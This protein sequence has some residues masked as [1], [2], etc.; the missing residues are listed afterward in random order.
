MP[1]LTLVE[2]TTSTVVVVD[3]R[4]LVR[5]GIAASLAPATQVTVEQR[6]RNRAGDAI[7]SLGPDVLVVVLRD[8]DPTLFDLIATARGVAPSLGILVLCDSVTG[9]D[10]REAVLSGVDSLLLTKAPLGE[11]RRA[12][13]ATAAGDRVVSPEIAMHLAV[14]TRAGTPPPSSSLTAR[15]LEVLELLAEGLTNAQVAKRLVLSPRTVKTH[16]QNLLTKLD[17]SHRT[18]AVARGFRLGLL[19]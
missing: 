10:L 19:R 7:R 11:L 4:P 5:S 1:A 12:V 14:S 17:A 13:L 15:E 8:D 18:A 6:A 9:T 16:V 2:T 3:D